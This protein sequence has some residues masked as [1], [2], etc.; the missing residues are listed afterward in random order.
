MHELCQFEA[1]ADYLIHVFIIELLI[2]LF[3]M[4]RAA[5]DTV[6]KLPMGNLGNGVEAAIW[7]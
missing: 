5:S 7:I 4:C 3:I 1:H 2:W 6:Q